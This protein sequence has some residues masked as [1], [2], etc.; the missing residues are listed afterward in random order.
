METEDFLSFGSKLA[1]TNVQVSAVDLKTDENGISD[2]SKLIKG[3]CDGINFP[4]VFKQKREGKFN[5]ILDTGWANLFLI[6]ENLKNILEDRKLTGWNVFPI[7]LYG[8]SGNEIDG[9]YGFSIVGHSGPTNYDA[10]ELVEKRKV[11]NG[12]LSQYYKGLSFD[13]WD[14]SDFFTPDKTYQIFI[15]KRA[16]EI[17]KNHKITNLQTESLSEKEMPVSHVRK[18]A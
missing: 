4:I 2:H 14:G 8:L 3:Q 6:S 1:S 10:S 5:D 13:M 9:Y 7:R 12:P 16:V 18:N 15:T 11:P 17:L